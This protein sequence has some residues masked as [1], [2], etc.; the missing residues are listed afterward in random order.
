MTDLTP[1][2]SSDPGLA[3]GAERDGLYSWPDC[4]A[5]P[6]QTVRELYQAHIGRSQVKA[7]TLLGTGHTTIRHAEGT[8]ITTDDG[9]QILDLTGGIGVL[10][11]GH[12]HP[13]ILA[14]RREFQRLK[15]MEVHKGFLSKYLA[16]LSHNLARL[17]PGD[18]DVFFMCNSG[19]EAVEGAVKLAYKVH[20]GRRRHIL[21][22]HNSFHGKL[23]GSSGLTAFAEQPFS[24]PTIPGIEVFEYDQIASVEGKIR[25]LRGAD[26][27]CDVYAIILEPYCVNHLRGC[28]PEFMA[29]LRE[30]CTRERIVLIF[31]EVY[32]GWGK[33]G[34]L[35]HFMRHAGL[36]PDILTMSKTFGGGKASLS[37]YMTRT[38]VYRKAY[39][40]MRD[41]MLHTSTYNGFGEE[42]VTALEAI[43]IVV[44]EDLPARARQIQERLAP[45]LRQLQAKYLELI[46]DVRGCGAHH[47]IFFRARLPRAVMSLFGLADGAGEGQANVMAKLMTTAVMAE[48]Y[49][50]HGMLTY[51]VPT[52]EV[53]L[54]V[55][56]SLVIADRDLDRFLDALDQTL[57]LGKRKL[58]SRLARGYFQTD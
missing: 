10:G 5:L 14:A 38:P 53:P 12:N 28:S 24:F 16:G 4:D 41:F 56:P 21:H 35:F 3:H 50:G 1:D 46:A 40:N 7:L 15:R 11:L 20:G 52:Q 55:S 6:P 8:L 32:T 22:A 33:T 43:R 54:I 37:G 9:R 51:C 36:V 34:T 19:A 31:D 58:F 57:A 23:L 18:L 2:T 47:G 49:R 25:E 48:L 26:G 42:C 29:R 27:Q 13:R 39:D 45:G 44:E 30:L 17:L